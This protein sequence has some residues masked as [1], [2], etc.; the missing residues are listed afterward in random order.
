MAKKMSRLRILIGSKKCFKK[1]NVFF[2]FK[3]DEVS[4][5]L[6]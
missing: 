1:V 6:I 5:G 2:I 4:K 3:V